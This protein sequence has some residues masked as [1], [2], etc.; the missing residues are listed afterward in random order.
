MKQIKV[1]VN[2]GK[3]YD[4]VI[5]NKGSWTFIWVDDFGVEKETTYPEAAVAQHLGNFN[6][7]VVES[8]TEVFTQEKFAQ[9]FNMWQDDFCNNPRAYE[10]ASDTAMRHLKEKLDGKEPSYGAVAAQIF[11]QYLT[12]LENQNV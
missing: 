12:T 7:V 1:K 6:W 2:G 3:T 8:S 10:I 11:Q 4:V 9:A 5:D